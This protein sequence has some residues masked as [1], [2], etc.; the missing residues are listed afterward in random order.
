LADR[1]QRSAQEVTQ[2]LIEARGEPVPPALVQTACAVRWSERGLL[3][4]VALHPEAARQPMSFLLA[5]MRLALN[6]E[7]PPPGLLFT[8]SDPAN[9]D[10]GG[11]WAA[12]QPLAQPPL[13]DRLEQFIVQRL[14]A[15]P[16][17]ADSLAG[18]RPTLP[19]WPLVWHPMANSKKST[20]AYALRTSLHNAAVTWP[21][22]LAC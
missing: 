10:T 12:E 3:N 19:W 13:A 21:M 7:L 20:G 6:R 5:Q 2:Q 8:P 9:P 22:S 4:E 1:L 11:L 16:V 17:A 15:G 14:E 18:R